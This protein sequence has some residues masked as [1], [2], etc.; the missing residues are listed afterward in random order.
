MTEDLRRSRRRF[1]AARGPD[2]DEPPA[3]LARARTV[4]R[5]LDESIRVPGTSFRIGLDPVFGLLPV[6]GDTVALLGSLYI[7]LVGVAL[8][9]PLRVVARMALLVALDWAVGSIPVVGTA[10]DAVFKV[11]T[12][13]VAV[14]ERAVRATS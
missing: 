1:D 12:R 7:V 11:N 10:F 13:N 2:A 4:A 6:A 8:G 9:V 3:A 14:I 5:V